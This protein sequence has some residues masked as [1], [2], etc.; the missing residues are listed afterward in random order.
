MS[1]IGIKC[2]LEPHVLVKWGNHLR[3]TGG[4]D[5]VEVGEFLGRCAELISGAGASS[6]NIDDRMREIEARAV[7]SMEHK[8]NEVM[9]AAGEL[10]SRFM[11]GDNQAE[12][13]TRVLSAAGVKGWNG[14]RQAGDKNG[15]IKK[16][17]AK[18]E[19]RKRKFVGGGVV[20][21]SKNG[22]VVSTV[23][24]RN[25]DNGAADEMPKRGGGAGVCSTLRADKLHALS[26]NGWCATQ[27][28]K[29]GF[30]I[31]HIARALGLG[32]SPEA[33]TEVWRKISGYERYWKR[34]GVAGVIK[35][36]PPQTW[37][38]K[39]EDAAM[40]ARG[41]GRSDG[42]TGGRVVLNGNRDCGSGTEDGDEA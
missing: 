31:R 17:R 32:T 33:R 3:Q 27:L 26:F 2:D 38:N 36:S 29:E 4:G 24:R 5:G 37:L 42:N 15:G 7:A 6:I 1:W 19:S 10:V 13:V 22:S 25:I 40:I 23:E 35:P 8:R 34:Q 41:K 21:S 16:S 9:F 12:N 14:G 28:R 11:E 20:R 18:S 30:K 39:L